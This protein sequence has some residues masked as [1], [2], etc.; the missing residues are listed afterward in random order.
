M[1][2]NRFGH[3]MAHMHHV[4]PQ[5]RGGTEHP[6]NL[7]TLCYP[8]HATKASR[9]HWR[10]LKGTTANLLPHF[11]KW[12]VWDLGLNMIGYAEWINPWRFPADQVLKDLRDWKQ[13]VDSAIEWAERVLEAAPSCMVPA[14][15]FKPRNTS[16]ELEAL[17]T[18]LRIGWV[19]HVQQPR[20]D[21]KIRKAY[22]RRQGK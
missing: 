8:C 3:I 19:A 21:E 11:V 6:D 22:A 1:P 5:A 10:L 20:L 17:I 18:G 13:S 9:G 15:K 12:L 7:L 16:Q 14:Q 2:H 4:V